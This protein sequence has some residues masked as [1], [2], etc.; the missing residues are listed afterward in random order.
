LSGVASS[1]QIKSGAIAIGPGGLIGRVTDVSSHSSRV[2]LISDPTSQVGVIISRTSHMGMLRGQAQN[3][4]MLEFFERDPDVSPG[5]IVL[6]SPYSTLYP[7]GIP[8]GQN[9]K[10]QSG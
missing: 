10:H 3:E 1:D 8:S 6:T 4:A 7:P 9:Q 5:D 2:L